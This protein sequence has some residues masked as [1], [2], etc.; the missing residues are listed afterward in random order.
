M[1]AILL[2]MILFKIHLNYHNGN[3]VHADKDLYNQTVSLLFFVFLLF[4][5]YC[6]IIHFYFSSILQVLFIFVILLFYLFGCL[7]SVS[8]SLHYSVSL[9]VSLLIKCETGECFQLQP[10]RLAWIGNVY[11]TFQC[12][13]RGSRWLILADLS[14]YLF[15]GHLCSWKVQLYSVRLNNSSVQTSRSKPQACR[16]NRVNGSVGVKHLQGYKVGCVC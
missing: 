9:L 8:Q 1:L 16:V 5:F 11:R 10:L 12:V 14:L 15:V 2:R 6:P 3:C 4:S 7:I 13:A